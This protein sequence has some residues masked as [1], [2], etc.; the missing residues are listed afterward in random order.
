MSAD[1]NLTRHMFY[2]AT[3]FMSYENDDPDYI[4]SSQ[5]AAY[6]SDANTA[7][8][9]LHCADGSVESKRSTE[10]RQH[11]SHQQAVSFIQVQTAEEAEGDQSF[12]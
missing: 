3:K 11:F 9:Y 4:T 7:W 2:R 6:I 5:R 12:T 1:I 8:K 10:E